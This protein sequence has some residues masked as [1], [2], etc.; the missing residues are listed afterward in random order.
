ML[1][2]DT[3][4][5]GVRVAMLSAGLLMIVAAI[6]GLSVLLAVAYGLMVAWVNASLLWWR[7]HRGEK[8]YHC[9]GQR[10]LKSFYRS[11]ME[12]FFVVGILL[13]AGFGILKLA[14][15]ALLLGFVV[16][17]LIWMVAGLTLRE[18]R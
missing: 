17:Q 14:P 4:R 16:G 7:W 1:N 18:R 9:D 13:A 10:H 12:R 6:A 5:I 8:V 2:R 15:L 11:M 3:T